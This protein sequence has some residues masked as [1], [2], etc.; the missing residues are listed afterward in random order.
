MK[1]WICMCMAAVMLLMGA[2]A[3]KEGPKK[4]SGA[5]FTLDGEAVS[6][7]EYGWYLFN[8]RVIFEQQYGYDIWYDSEVG[9]MAYDMAREQALEWLRDTKIGVAQATKAG[10]EMSAED[11][12][13]VKDSAQ[14][15]ITSMKSQY[16]EDFLTLIDATAADIESIVV[17]S[18][19]FN[20]LYDLIVSEYLPDAAAMAVEY[21][22]FLVENK[23]DYIIANANCIQVEDLETAEAIL[24]RLDE[25]EDFLALM[26]EF[27]VLYDADAEDPNAPIALYMLGISTEDLTKSVEMEVGEVSGAV[28][29]YGGYVIFKVTSIDEPDY[30]ELEVMFFDS[31]IAAKME[32]EF[33]TQS[34]SWAEAAEYVVDEA[35]FEAVEIP[36]LPRASLP[37]PEGTDEN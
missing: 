28:E 7:Q 8:Q 22:T 26:E 20:L 1:K 23:A 2:C 35:V 6:S 14:G 33:V 5:I 13:T 16:G 12:V 31:Y 34:M 25:G 29:S 3:P 36:G 9:V 17:D 30:A 32:E 15:Y 19:M 18:M 4:S 10:I 24:G 37:A 11:W 21:E 27:S